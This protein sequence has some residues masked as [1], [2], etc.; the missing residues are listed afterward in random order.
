[1]I[2]KF[3]W[4]S[5]TLSRH[6]VAK[7]GQVIVF[8]SAHLSY[9]ASWSLSPLDSRRLLAKCQT[10]RVRSCHVLHPSS[11]IIL[12]ANML[13][14]RALIV[15][16]SSAHLYFLDTEFSPKNVNLKWLNTFPPIST[17]AHSICL[18]P[19]CPVRSPNACTTIL[20]WP[21]LRLLRFS[22]RKVMPTLSDLNIMASGRNRDSV[23][24]DRISSSMSIKLCWTWYTS[25]RG[26]WAG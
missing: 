23:W 9:T 4:R 7:Q 5:L 18:G 26:S 20:A 8:A 10:C 19:Y 6:V 22:P 1:M 13:V 3:Y 12:M 24:P 25:I 21:L 16:P 11:S 2:Q 14:K 17:F 15:Q